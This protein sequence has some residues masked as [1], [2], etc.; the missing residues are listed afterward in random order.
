MAEFDEVSQ[1]IAAQES[2]KDFV[3]TIDDGKVHTKNAFV[4]TTSARKSILK[5]CDSTI[6][7]LNELINNG[8]CKSKVHRNRLES[9]LD[10][11]VHKMLTTRNEISSSFPNFN[12]VEADI[13]M[14]QIRIAA[15]F[16]KKTDEFKDNQREFF[17][18]LENKLQI[19]GDDI[20]NLKM[21]L[22]L[23]VQAINDLK[24]QTELAEDYL[25]FDEDPALHEQ[26]HHY[27]IKT[28]KRLINECNDYRNEHE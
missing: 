1:Q 11:G 28:A 25:S 6:P 19:L 27:I 16:E 20:R 8:G 5:W 26:L 18:N 9:S 3:N 23:E 22:K 10:N 7:H 4:L 17:E 15:D 14:A 24:V 21:Q 13:F 12:S 2:V